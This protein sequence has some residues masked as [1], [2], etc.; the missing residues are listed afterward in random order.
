MKIV[1]LQQRSPDWYKWRD[2][3]IGSSDISAIDGSNPYK[4]SYQTW[5]E[6]MGLVKKVDFVNPNMQRGIDYE[7]EAREYLG[8]PN[9][10]PECIEHSTYNFFHASLD[11]LGDGYIAEIKVPSPQNF[12]SYESKIPAYYITQVQWQLLVSGLFYCKF[13][14]YSPELKKG[15]L[16]VIQRDEVMIADLEKIAIKFWEDFENGVEP[17]KTADDEMEEKFGDEL[18]W[19]C[20]SYVHWQEKKGTV[21]DNLD[22]FREKILSFS[23]GD[24]FRSYG[25]KC[26]KMSPR[27]TYDMQAMKSDGID[28]D[29]YKKVHKKDSFMIRVENIA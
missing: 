29:K 7:D 18:R 22:F 17:K 20:D 13:L 28:I 1:K 25:L 15:H 8:D 23:Q 4:T 6:K 10:R 27:S 12:A 9:L 16:H 26:I 2:E 24:S 3:G 14:A 19:A 5:Q 11:G 21:E